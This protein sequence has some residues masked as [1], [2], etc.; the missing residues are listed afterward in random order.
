LF[1]GIVVLRWTQVELAT[2]SAPPAGA[3]AGALHPAGKSR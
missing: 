1:T 3:D 2:L